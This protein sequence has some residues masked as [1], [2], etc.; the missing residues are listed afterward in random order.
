M[1][2]GSTPETHNTFFQCVFSFFFLLHLFECFFLQT[3]LRNW[4]RISSTCNIFIC[5]LKHHSM[6]SQFFMTCLTLPNYMIFNE[7]HQKYLRISWFWEEPG[8]HD[9]IW[10]H[11]KMSLKPLTNDLNSSYLSQN[12]TKMTKKY[13][14]NNEIWLVITTPKLKLLFILK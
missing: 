1:M 10:K 2:H 6:T 8:L 12:M 11:N 7:I 3:C 14:K 5:L 4:D 9:S 13:A